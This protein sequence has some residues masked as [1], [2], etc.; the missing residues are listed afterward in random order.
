M[1]VDTEENGPTWLYKTVMLL[2]SCNSSVNIFIY[3]KYNK[4]FRLECMKLFRVKATVV[5]SEISGS[6]GRTNT[7]R[8]S[9][10]TSTL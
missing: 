7:N 5:D 6:T 1:F 9:R 8:Q 10:V 2:V 4:M 3:L